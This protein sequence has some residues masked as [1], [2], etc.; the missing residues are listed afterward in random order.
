MNSTIQHP[1]HLHGVSQQRRI[2]LS[3]TLKLKNC[4]SMRS[5]SSEQ[6]EAARTI[7]RTLFKE[8]SSRLDTQETT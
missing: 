2:K 5:V 3:L 1:F 8:M 6:Q 7:M 4:Y